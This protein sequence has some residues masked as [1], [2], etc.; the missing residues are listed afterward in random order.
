MSS[1]TID[2]KTSKF[3]ENSKIDGKISSFLS[4]VDE[5]TTVKVGIFTQKM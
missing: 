4:M 3:T 2:K 5:L 1:S